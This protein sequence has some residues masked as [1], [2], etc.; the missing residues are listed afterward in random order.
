MYRNFEK[1]TQDKKD[2]I[3]SACL[4]EFAKGYQQASTNAIVRKAGIPKGTLFYF[5]GNKKQL[6]LYILDYTINKFLSRFKRESI[7]L[8][9]DIFER[10]E[11]RGL[12]KLKIAM[13][14]PL[15][16]EII[17]K[18]VVDV[19]GYLKGEVYKNYL[20][21]AAESES[22]LY[23]GIDV[24]RFREG[25]DIKRA[26]EVITMFLEGYLN[27]HMD[28]LKKCTASESIKLYKKISSE[29]KKYFEIIKEGIYK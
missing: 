1:I 24:S 25:M 3:I 2:R 19:P 8:S 11:Q 29:V 17:Y 20:K 4:K 16:Y 12:L 13:E 9:S 7:S 27:R 14:E 5:F 10:L 22:S 26:V 21:F 6:Y 18:S 15:L 23:R 28:V